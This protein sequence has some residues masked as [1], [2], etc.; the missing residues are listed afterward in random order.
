MKLIFW[1]FIVPL[2]FIGGVITGMIRGGAEEAKK[3]VKELK[4]G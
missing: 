2:G 1:I 4:D 3:M